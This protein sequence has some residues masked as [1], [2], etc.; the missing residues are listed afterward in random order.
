MNKN[1]KSR[2]A[3]RLP[4]RSRLAEAGELRIG[5]T[6]CGMSRHML[7]WSALCAALLMSLPEH[8]LAQAAATPATA[9]AT[10]PA[11]PGQVLALIVTGKSGSGIYARRY[12]DWA[13]RFH[14]HLTKTC[15]VPAENV[16]LL[17]GDKDFKAAPVN[18]PASADGI[19]KAVAQ[20]AGRTAPQDQFVLFIVGHG[21]LADS[22]AG[23]V[24]PGSDLKG[25]KLADALKAI[26]CRN[27]VI[28]HAGGASGDF[29]APLARMGRVIV[30][31]TSPEEVVE[32]VFAEFFLRAIEGGACDGQGAAKDGNLTVLE[33]FNWAT[34]Q[35]ALW[36]CRQR[37]TENDGWVVEGK[38]SIELFKK[39][40]D[41]PADQ[42]G[43]RQLSSASDA[44]K[45]D[46]PV[47]ITVPKT[48]ENLETYT[49]RRIVTEHALLE[50]AGKEDGRA[51]LRGE[52]GYEALTPAAR[53][54]ASAPA[55]TRPASTP[56]VPGELSSRTVIGKPALLP[57]Q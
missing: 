11:R 5:L 39:L 48:R 49:G 8:A 15:K 1:N 32:P 54:A 40:Y 4:R 38:Q 30:T 35:T 14:A 56:S 31:A 57:A 2:L 37:A 27:Q 42:P 9:P 22:V 53:P 34:H 23:L 55:S 13:S 10:A 6:P 47:P 45:D 25:G 50:D 26:P 18:G 33:A 41:G 43:Y 7:A 3:N 52:T 12:Q 20:L 24:L 46:A 44:S 16:V 51:A 19:A 28:V 29:L 36:I 21:N 17:S